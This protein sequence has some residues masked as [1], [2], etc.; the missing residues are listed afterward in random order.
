MSTENAKSSFKRP[1]SYHDDFGDFLYEYGETTKSLL[2]EG[3]FKEYLDFIVPREMV[4]LIC[5]Y[6]GNGEHEKKTIWSVYM[7]RNNM[8]GN[9]VISPV[10]L[11]YAKLKQWKK[12]INGNHFIPGLALWIQKLLDNIMRD[13]MLN[14]IYHQMVMDLIYP[15]DKLQTT[16][17][18][19]GMMLLPIGIKYDLFKIL[20]II[21]QSK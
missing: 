3:I 7:K 13:F 5:L 16:Q 4:E 11:K 9:V 1:L 10:K 18:S 6:F 12:T 21:F 8:F 2:I 17:R 14:F 19:C 15:M 20:Y